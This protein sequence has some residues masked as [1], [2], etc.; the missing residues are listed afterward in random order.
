M[1]KDAKVIAIFTNDR[2]IRMWSPIGQ[3]EFCSYRV[4]FDVMDMQ[5]SSD[6]RRL[7]VQG[8]GPG[9]EAVFEVFEVKN[10]DDL[11]VSVPERKQ[12]IQ[13][14]VNLNLSDERMRGS[15]RELSGSGGGRG[16]II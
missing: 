14:E 10:I 5:M 15:S 9:L 3:S 12:S 8:A 13:R 6:C 7:V 2:T 11:L 16:L 1:S 4:T